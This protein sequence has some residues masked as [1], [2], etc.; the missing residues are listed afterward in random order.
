[1]ITATRAAD[2][3]CFIRSQNG[4]QDKLQRSFSPQDTFKNPFPHHLFFSQ[5]K[6][7]P[8]FSG[9]MARTGV[10]G[11][12]IDEVVHQMQAGV[13]TPQYLRVN[14]YCAPY[15]GKI[16]PFV[17]NNQTWVVFSRAG[18]DASRVVPVL[19]TQDALN[20]IKKMDLLNPNIICN[21]LACEEETTTLRPG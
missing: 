2:I 9:K 12:A 18:I 5:A 17:F 14:M 20:R 16:H 13:I 1:M 8:G 21:E 3:A 6:H 19:P 4:L 11:V 7:A 10:S 15:N